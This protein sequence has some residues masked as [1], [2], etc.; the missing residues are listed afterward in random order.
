MVALDPSV[1]FNALYA[2]WVGSW[3][4]HRLSTV[5]VCLQELPCICDVQ[6]HVGWDAVFYVMVCG[7]EGVHRV[8]RAWVR[9]IE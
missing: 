9:I 1:L 8:Y 3:E 5:A 7:E 2:V 4:A 6:R